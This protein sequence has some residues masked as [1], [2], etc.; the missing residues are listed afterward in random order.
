MV[1]GACNCLIIG[2][3]GASGSGKS[4]LAHTIH[5]ELASELGEHQ[6]GVITEDCYYRDQSQLSMEARAATNYDHPA[7]FDHD[8]LIEHLTRLRRGERVA[9]PRYSYTEH[10]NNFV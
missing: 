9:I 7:A 10:R 2:I 8:L 4:L 6:I 3:T 1:E 5:D